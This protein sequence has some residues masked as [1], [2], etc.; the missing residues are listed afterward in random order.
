MR[1]KSTYRFI[2]APFLWLTFALVIQQIA[3]YFPHKTEVLY[4]SHLYL[5]ISAFFS[6]CTGWFAQSLAEI[7]IYLAFLFLIYKSIALILSMYRH[8]GLKTFFHRHLFARTFSGLGLLYLLFL[9]L[10]GLNYFRLPL[11]DLVGLE[12]GQ[13]KPGE[14]Q[15]LCGHLISQANCLRGSL[16]EDD[17]GVMVLINNRRALLDQVP[18]AYTRAAQVYPFLA[19]RTGKPKYLLASPL[20]SHLGIAGFYFPFTGEGNVN[21]DL[22]DAFIPFTACHEIA[23]QKGFAREDEANYIAYLACSCH[24]DLAYQYSGVLTALVYSINMLA[25]SNP[26]AAQELRRL[27]SPGVRR[28]LLAWQAF[29]QEHHN[30]LVKIFA[31]LNHLYLKSNQ[32]PEGLASYNQMVELLLADYR[33]RHSGD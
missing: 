26:V 2:S 5:L 17:Q 28:D 21:A 8:N 13:A 9:L 10:W 1:Q 14:L 33:S 25:R 11:A 3:L 19:G 22:P 15:Q 12:V 20:F 29:W 18:D 7:I 24:N 16:P 4:G 27:Y 30:P 32:Q 31:A 23:H 6:L